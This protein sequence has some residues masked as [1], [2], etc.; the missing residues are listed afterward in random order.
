MRTHVA[1]VSVLISGIVLAAPGTAQAPGSDP[2]R[3]DQIDWINPPIELSPG[4]THDTFRSRS[5]DREVGYSIYLP[6]GY[7]ESG[8]IYPVV[9]W[10]HGRSGNESDTRPAEALHEAIQADGTQ[11]MVLVLANGGV[12]S[13][14]IDNPHTGVMGES[15]VVEDLIPHVEANYRVHAEPGGRGLGGFSMGGA[16]A[17][18][19]AL[20]HPEL[21]GSIV[22]V[23]GVLVGSVEI[24]ERNS[25]VD[26]DLAR[27]YD[28]YPT[29]V[30]RASRLRRVGIK[31][32]V[33]TEDRWI[34]EN[35]RFAAH[36]GH[37]NLQI[38]Y[39]ELRRIDHDL[40]DYLAT[41]GRD[42][43]GFFSRRLER[44]G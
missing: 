26:P 28:P 29:A 14:Y 8:L 22:S 9:Y 13:G 43:F 19:I 40:S 24:M 30:D 38:D 7:E 32:L 34:A 39:Q 42:L 41:A 3:V 31:I 35:R 20:R 25:V 27:S 2:V 21:F 36:L 4:L 5:M 15:V 44:G 12:A 1:A 16:G 6:P 37:Q 18:R 10:L 11:P 23:A 17:I 33:G